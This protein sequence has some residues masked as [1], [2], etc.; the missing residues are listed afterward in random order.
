MK[1]FN[2]NRLKRSNSSKI[3]KGTL[4]R[5]EMNYLKGGSEKMF[6]KWTDVIKG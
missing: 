3:V 2:V 5:E 1:I 4:K 6:N